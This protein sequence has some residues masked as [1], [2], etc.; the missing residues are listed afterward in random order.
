MCVC[1]REGGG[2]VRERG[3]RQS[4]RERERLTDKKRN[5]QAGR[6]IRTETRERQRQL[7]KN[8]NLSLPLSLTSGQ[9]DRTS[10]S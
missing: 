2:R 9:S 1:E 3:E 4:G 5:T 6:G 10:S 7:F 8:T